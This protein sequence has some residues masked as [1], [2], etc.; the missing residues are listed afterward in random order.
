MLWFVILHKRPIT[1]QPQFL[2]R[3]FQ[4]LF[5]NLLFFFF[6]IHLTLASFSTLCELKQPQNIKLSPSMFDCRGGILWK[7]S[8]TYPS[9]HQYA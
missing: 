7:V 2:G 1:S 8:F 9:I 6:I 5:Q 4:V 3:F